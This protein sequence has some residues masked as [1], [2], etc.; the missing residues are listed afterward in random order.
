MHRRGEVWIVGVLAA[1]LM[2]TGVGAASAS[3][4]S[5]PHAAPQVVSADGSGPDVGSAAAAAAAKAAGVDDADYTEAQKQAAEKTAAAKT[6]TKTCK[7]IVHWP[8]NNL[9]DDCQNAMKSHFVRDQMPTL[10]AHTVCGVVSSING[11]L[12]TGC[13][14]VV[15]PAMDKIKGWFWDAYNVALT[16]ASTPYNAAKA[17]GFM[18]NPKYAW[19][20]F[21]N[22]LK[23]D[24][25]SMFETAMDFV[26]NTVAFDPSATWWRNAYAASG[27]IGLLL[28]A[29]GLIL[30]F[31]SY[32]NGR[33][34]PDEMSDTLVRRVPIALLMMVF[35]PAVAYV[36]MQVSNG[37]SEGVIHWM[38]PDAAKSLTSAAVFEAITMQIPGGFVTGLIVF[39][40]LFIGALGI[41]GTFMVQT[42]TTYIL[43]V[44]AGMGW[45]M[46]VYSPWRKKSL[47][48]PFAV[49]VL[50]FSRPLLLFAVGV[51]FK[52]AGG[53]D[54]TPSSAS[55][56]LKQLVQAAL[57]VI[58]VVFIA[59]AP[60]TLLKWFPLMPTEHGV[61]SGGAM[62]TAAAVGMAGSSLQTL[63]M[64]RA[65]NEKTT[66]SNTQAGP[67][68]GPGPG[69]PPPGP[70]PTPTPA[71]VPNPAGAGTGAGA[72][73][74]AG[75]G[76]GA[77]STG[78]SAA[79][80]AASGGALLAAQLAAQAAQAVVEKTRASA[81]AA[82]PEIA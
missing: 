68:P 8:L 82:T 54:P 30:Q 15:E 73:V 4:P 76:A 53:V 6:A 25:V 59:F 29:I 13:S 32:G 45:G 7:L 28:L 34:G 42:L 63:A 67:N 16:A 22:S 69:N 81:D 56:G 60:W 21:I 3:A 35:G 26:V 80:G 78:A 2:C 75:A 11:A 51:V 65:R 72:G 36:I 71:A 52:M 40:I 66:A 55:D 19:Q 9:Q 12:G 70:R 31:H 44:A 41:I 33:I 58:A 62:M 57:V 49:V 14:V 50:I 18:V 1:V 20:A 43:G 74:G 48:V 77:A 79:G 38:G 10:A 27:G 23:E 37:L 47:A 5:S 24:A 17:V 61:R 64:N 46:S 39:G